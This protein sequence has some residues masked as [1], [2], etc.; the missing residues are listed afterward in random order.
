MWMCGSQ[1]C[2]LYGA[3]RGGRAVWKISEKSLYP[4]GCGSVSGDWDYVA[5]GNYRLYGSRCG[6]DR[7][8]S[9]GRAGSS[10]GLLLEIGSDCFDDACGI[11]WW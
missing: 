6:T 9:G 10:S 3:E 2:F 7:E 5:S 8:G 11:P 4:C 1:Y